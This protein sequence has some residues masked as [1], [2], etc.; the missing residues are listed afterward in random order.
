M[1][2]R[3]RAARRSREQDR[4]T[5]A[6]CRHV[7]CGH[8]RTYARPLAGRDA[9]FGRH[10]KFCSKTRDFRYVSR[11]TPIRAPPIR[12][13]ARRERAFAANSAWP[14]I[15]ELDRSL[16]RDPDAI[17]L[18][19]ERAG[20][21]RE[22]GLFEGAER[23]Y[24]ELLHHTPTDF[25]VL[26]DFG[27]MVLTAGYKDAARSLFGEAIRHHPEN[28]TG[29][30]NLGEFAVFVRRARVGAHAFRG[31][32]AVD[33]DPSTPTAASAISWPSRA[34]R[35]VRENITT[36]PTPRT[37]RCGCRIAATVLRSRCYL[38]VSAAGGNI[39]TTSILD[40]RQ[41]AKEVLVTEYA[42]PEYAA[43]AARSRFRRASATP[44]LRRRS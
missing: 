42:E 21:L 23:D 14:H 13:I 37:F 1:R 32:A 2:L 15:E 41:F 44:T 24:L 31:G 38:S 26:N 16:A 6:A 7:A 36:R 5:H 17:A 34:T 35:P 33:P 43:T 28:P 25:A 11:Q 4:P 20:L 22:R 9:S 3:R 18:R 30:V 27:T 8:D 10:G 29:H 12:D 19:F 39:P 40:D